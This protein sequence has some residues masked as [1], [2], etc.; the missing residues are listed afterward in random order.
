MKVK[1]ERSTDCSDSYL[2]PEGQVGEDGQVLGPFHGH[3]EK[4]SRGLVHVLRTAG[5]VE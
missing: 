4:A 3:K 2:I 5:R 1:G